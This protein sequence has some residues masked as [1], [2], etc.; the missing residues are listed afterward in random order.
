MTKIF[1]GLEDEGPPVLPWHGSPRHV[2]SQIRKKLAA[3]NNPPPAPEILYEAAPEWLSVAPGHHAVVVGRVRYYF[4]PMRLRDVTDTFEEGTE[5]KELREPWE[6]AQEF[7]PGAKLK[8]VVETVHDEQEVT[9][10]AAIDFAS[11]ADFIAYMVR[12]R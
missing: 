2:L 12:W 10:I 6:W 8:F 9:W 11:E 7:T 4:K 1:D 3:R 5:F